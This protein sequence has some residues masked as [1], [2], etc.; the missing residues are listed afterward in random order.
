MPN[1]T[2]YIAPE[3]FSLFPKVSVKGF[4]RFRMSDRTLL[5]SHTAPTKRFW[6]V[7]DWLNPA[8]GGCIPSYHDKR[9][10]VDGLLKTAGR[11]QEFVCQPS[12]NHNFEEWL[13]DLFNEVITNHEQ[14]STSAL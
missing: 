1:N 8:K 3:T 2:I 10:Y 11:G 13:L 7:P 12:Q 14:S 9:N 5:S 4:G 6:N